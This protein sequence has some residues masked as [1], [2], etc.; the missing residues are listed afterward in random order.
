MGL[1]MICDEASCY[2]SESA[3]TVDKYTKNNSH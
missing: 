3:R 1:I 2:H